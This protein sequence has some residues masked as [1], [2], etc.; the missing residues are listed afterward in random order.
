MISLRVNLPA[1]EGLA[2]SLSFDIADDL[3]L[4]FGGGFTATQSSRLNLI[5]A[6]LLTQNM[7]LQMDP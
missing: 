6:H 2:V 5:M 7:L 3:D 4:D 1:N